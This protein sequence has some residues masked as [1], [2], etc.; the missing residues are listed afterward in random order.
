MQAIAL[1]QCNQTEEHQIMRV[2]QE[3]YD[4]NF[5]TRFSWDCPAD[6]WAEQMAA[7]Q[8]DAKPLSPES[9]AL[10]FYQGQDWI[11]GGNLN[12]GRFDPLPRKDASKLTRY[13]EG[14]DHI[15][16]RLSVF[17]LRICLREM[18]HGTFIDSFWNKFNPVPDSPSENERLRVLAKR[19]EHEPGIN[20]CN[21]Y[22]VAEVCRVCEYMF[23][24]GSWGS[25]YGGEKWAHIADTLC[26]FCK[27]SITPEIFCDRAFNLAHNTS[28]IFNKGG[29]FS[30]QNSMR[31][32]EILN[33]QAKGQISQYNGPI[34]PW[35]AQEVV[36]IKG[37]APLLFPWTKEIV[38]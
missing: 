35:G 37:V 15:T 30:P 1:V 7:R 32:L 13:L 14:V 27:G 25:A 19:L 4:S 24:Y 36:K 29:E 18:R 17:I 8:M 3:F 38:Q 12:Y 21:G 28:P 31:L 26:D 20:K 23:K 16:V 33:A 5:R 11:Y 10:F 34:T 22:T 6:H 9:V 2:L